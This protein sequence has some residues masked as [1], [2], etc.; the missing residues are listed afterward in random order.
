MIRLP[1]KLYV[2]IAPVNL[3]F[4]FDRLAG[5]VRS[6]L[7]GDPRSEAAFVFH[8]RRG[9][10]VK[11]LWFDGV[12]YCI[13][14]RRLDRGAYRIPMAIPQGATSVTVS[15]RELDVLLQG[16]D[17]RLLRAARRSVRARA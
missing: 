10:H 2:A 13:F 17:R 1:A 12:G 11:I 15:R 6:E 9:T 16:I 5:I 3:H 4:S 14:F 7:G 8:N